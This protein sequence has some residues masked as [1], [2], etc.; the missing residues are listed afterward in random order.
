MRSAIARVT[1]LATLAS[2]ST[3]GGPGDG[4]APDGGRDV[5]TALDAP[6][7]LA[8]HLAAGRFV[9]FAL[10]APAT[11]QTREIAA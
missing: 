9:A 4:S 8:E 3:P 2:C 1:L 5:A 10:R 7:A 11:E 6:S